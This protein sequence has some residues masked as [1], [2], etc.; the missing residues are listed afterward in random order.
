L[1]YAEFKQFDNIDQYEKIKCSFQFW[2]WFGLG[3]EPYKHF[4]LT[5]TKQLSINKYEILVGL[6]WNKDERLSRFIP[7]TLE[8]VN[9][10]WQIT[11]IVVEWE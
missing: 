2:Q 11:N 3:I 5:E 10:D 4:E 7:V 6:A 1:K 8:R 9:G